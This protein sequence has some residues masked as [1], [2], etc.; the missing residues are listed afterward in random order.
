VAGSEDM[1]PAGPMTQYAF[2]VDPNGEVISTVVE[3]DTTAGTHVRVRLSEGGTG[4]R[5]A[6]IEGRLPKILED[7]S[8]L[9]A[10]AVGQQRL[11]PDK[12][13]FV[14][15]YVVNEVTPLVDGRVGDVERRVL[16][17][18]DVPTS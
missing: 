14:R 1:F 10:V 5:R 17:T 11:H 18:Y 2:Y 13:Q 6:S 12:P 9:R 15:L 16:V 4:I 8:L 7:P 3:A